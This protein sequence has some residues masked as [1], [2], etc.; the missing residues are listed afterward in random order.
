MYSH[1]DSNLASFIGVQKIVSKCLNI[2]RISDKSY[3]IKTTFTVDVRYN[4]LKRALTM[5][6][7][8]AL[9]YSKGCKLK[10]NLTNS[11]LA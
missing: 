10:K 7:T 9:Y 6:K 3:F 1:N 2:I 5:S 8:G 11:Y 4:M